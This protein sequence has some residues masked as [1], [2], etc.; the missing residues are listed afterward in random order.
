MRGE[1]GGEEKSTK[2]SGKGEA[3]KGAEAGERKKE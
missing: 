3:A 1:A 2:E